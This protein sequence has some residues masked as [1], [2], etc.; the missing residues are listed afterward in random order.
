MTGGPSTANL[1]WSRWTAI[2]GK[3]TGKIELFWCVP[4]A[5][6][7][8]TTHPVTVWANTGAA[9]ANQ[10]QDA[11]PPAAVTAISPTVQKGT[12]GTGGSSLT[13]AKA[14]KPGNSPICG[15]VTVCSSTT[16]RQTPKEP[17][18]IERI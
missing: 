8:P 15:H 1:R 10:D 17:N 3:A 4:I 16:E 12:S 5:T 9:A 11:S 2:S 7:K 13:S 6:C 18:P 14:A